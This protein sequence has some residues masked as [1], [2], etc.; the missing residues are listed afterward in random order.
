MAELDNQYR[1]QAVETKEK[2]TEPMLENKIQVA[3][4]VKE[5]NRDYLGA[6][7]R[8]GLWAAMKH[9]FDKRASSI[10]KIVDKE[11]QELYAL[12]LERG[13]ANTKSRLAENMRQRREQDL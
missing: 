2:L 5:L 12:G 9:A 8:A 10:N 4:K 1:L 7:K 3:P 11:G 6:K 13:A